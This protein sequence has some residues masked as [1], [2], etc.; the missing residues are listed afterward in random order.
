MSSKFL[1]TLNRF[2]FHV[3][4]YFPVVQ[5]GRFMTSNQKNKMVFFHL[6]LLQSLN[7]IS[8]TMI[9]KYNE[10]LDAFTLEDQKSHRK[11]HCFFLL[12]KK[13]PFL[14]SRF[15]CQVGSFNL[16]KLWVFSVAQP[17]VVYTSPKQPNKTWSH[18]LTHSKVQF[19]KIY[20]FILIYLFYR[21]NVLEA[22]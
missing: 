16:S 17:I 15:F 8:R 18:T 12:T 9:H 13:N 21:L 6:H 10:A 2:S 22:F 11:A 1:K 4:Y 19:F 7:D 3:I 5:S 20:L 14:Q